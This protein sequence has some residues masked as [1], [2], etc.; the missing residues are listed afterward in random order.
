MRV[1]F[2]LC[3][4]STEAE[5]L[6]RL[7]FGTTTANFVGTDGKAVCSGEYLSCA[8]RSPIAEENIHLIP[9]RDSGEAWVFTE[10]SNCVIGLLADAEI[11]LPAT[12]MDKCAEIKARLSPKPP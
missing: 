1:Y 7:L 5:C 3:N 2:F 8:T 12:E 9:P 10:R 11:L 4:H 6:T